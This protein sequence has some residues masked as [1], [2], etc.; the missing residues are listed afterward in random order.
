MA[1]K[2]E[3]YILEVLEKRGELKAVEISRLAKGHLG[4]KVTRKDINSA[5]YGALG[6]RVSKDPTS[7]R[8]SLRAGAITSPTASPRPSQQV[9][10]KPRSVQA[11]RGD[12]DD[13]AK[14]TRVELTPQQDRLVG[15]GLDGNL[16]IRGEAGSGKTTVLAARAGWVASQL[17]NGSLLFLAYN[18]GLAGYVERVLNALGVR[19]GVEVSTLHEWARSMA[20]NLGLRTKRWAMRG[21]RTEVLPSILDALGARWGDHR[22]LSQPLDFWHEEI[23]WIY[24]RG[25]ESSAEYR[26]AERR[27]RGTSVQL[28]GDDRAL[29]WEVFDTCRR[30]VSVDDQW[31]VDDPGGLVLEAVRRAGG[32]IPDSL[33]Y[34]HVFIDEVQDF[35]LSWLRAVVPTA[36]HS[37]SMAGDLAQRIY[38][39]QLTWKEAGIDLPPARSRALPGSRRSTRQ[40]MGVARHLAT[41]PDLRLEPD[42]VAPGTTFRDGEP[43]RRIVRRTRRDVSSAVAVDIQHRLLQAPGETIAV[44]APLQRQAYG[45]MKALESAGVA[46]KV[47]RGAK[48]GTHASTVEVMTFHQTKGLEWDHVYLVGLDDAT[49]PAVFLDRLSD[50]ME[51][52][53]EENRLR[54]LVYVAMTRA[55]R[56]L[57]LCGTEPWSRFLAEVP[58]SAFGM[59]H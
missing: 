21:A 20:S 54:R 57:V 56:S 53:D 32:S 55:R 40:I 41:N 5:L 33:R 1:S 6:D 15:F 3:R 59:T 12:V 27:G 42:Y 25:F 9:P 29:A 34:D 37:V 19:S 17:S 47:V 24:G 49:M 48:V 23:A 10:A 18:R 38:R 39:R 14:V 31:D 50:P 44:A 51:V 36:R 8:W 7:H 11:A 2:L 13:V 28:R 4:Q 16:L 35:D 22:L 46:A 52:E 26:T 43:V 30:R 45:V 58:D